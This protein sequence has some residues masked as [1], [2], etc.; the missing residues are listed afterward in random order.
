MRKIDNRGF[1]LVETI[2]TLVIMSLLAAVIGKVFIGNFN[3]YNGMSTTQIQ[4]I[5][6]D[7]V[8]E[9]L[10]DIV[11]DAMSVSIK[12]ADYVLQDGE[13]AIYTDDDGNL[14]IVGS[15]GASTLYTSNTGALNI[16]QL[17][18]VKSEGD[19][20]SLQFVLSYTNG[21]DELVSR[22]L[23]TQLFNV[24]TVSFDALAHSGD[25]GTY[26]LKDGSTSNMLV[27]KQAA[28]DAEGLTDAEKYAILS[29]YLSDPYYTP[30]DDPQTYIYGML[31]WNQ[32]QSKYKVFN[33]VDSIPYGGG[34]ITT[35]T[36]QQVPVDFILVLDQSG[37]MDSNLDGGK[38]R[39]QALK[40]A[41]RNFVGS[42]DDLNRTTGDTV[43]IVGFATNPDSSYASARGGSYQVTEAF[44]GNTG[45]NSSSYQDTPGW[46]YN[47]VIGWS[48]SNLVSKVVKNVES[49][50]SDIYNAINALKAEGA[51]AADLGMKLAER[52]VNAL[53]NNG[54]KKVVIMFTDGVPTQQSDFDE[55]VADGAIA[56]SKNMKQ[57]GV[58]VFAIKTSNAT[59]TNMDKYMNY[60]SSNYPNATDMDHPGTKDTSS[61]FYYNVSNTS[62]L[63]NVF[64]TIQVEVYT[65]IPPEYTTLSSEEYTTTDLQEY[66]PSAEYEVGDIVLEDSSLWWYDGT[67]WVEL[68]DL[69][70][71]Y[72][73]VVAK[74]EI[75]A[76]QIQDFDEGVQ[77][78]VGD[79]VLVSYGTTSHK[80][81]YKKVIAGTNGTDPSVISERISGGWQLQTNQ[82]DPNSCYKAG[83][84]VLV[85]GDYHTEIYVVTF[86]QDISA[87]NYNGVKTAI[88]NCYEND[89]LVE[90]NTAFSIAEF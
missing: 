8:N 60:V 14:I 71:D 38:T 36:T 19:S 44:D 62:A 78:E 27:Y 66:D 21:S 26:L 77:Y 45:P 88:Y 22:T 75:M 1:T 54:H 49:Q 84:K 76:A 16:L 56:A 86:D 83:D 18:V 74:D 28:Q 46:P 34:T 87:S 24:S 2:I 13:Y 12:P 57:Q 25:D 51:T 39:M 20:D 81:I 61:Q 35:I 80:E 23:T 47:T 17:S 69:Y 89:S 64:E 90:N 67:G 70:E 79:Y 52:I 5:S 29:Y 37:S 63:V 42:I 43:S 41:A 4:T 53:G 73:L 48:N 65:D 59:G 85:F 3:T 40:E 55:N 33:N 32:T 31:Y 7:G 15:D 6:L 30:D 10:N 58:D 82:Y 68:D 72:E 11:E 9:I 50:K